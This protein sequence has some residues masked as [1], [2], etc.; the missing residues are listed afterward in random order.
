MIE[1]SNSILA[2]EVWAI[3]LSTLLVSNVISNPLSRIV[4]GKNG[5][6]ADFPYQ[7]S[8]SLQ[9]YEWVVEKHFCGGSILTPLWILTAGHCVTEIPQIGDIYIRAGIN[10]LN[11]DGGQKSM[12]IKRIKHPD[13]AG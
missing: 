2:M 3:L 10:E 4:G 6:V 7:V 8:L 5:D 11:E 9:I 13:Y 12:V 1:S